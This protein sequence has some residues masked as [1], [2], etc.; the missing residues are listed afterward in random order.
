[1]VNH[2]RY[3]I[4]TLLLGMGTCLP[5]LAQDNCNRACMKS[6]VDS[7]LSAIVA[8]DPNKAPLATIYRHTE[9]DQVQPRGEGMW[10]TA[11]G[12]GA[13]QRQYFDEVTKNAVYYG[14]IKEGDILA[15]TAVRLHIE[16]KLI[17][18]A[19][20]FVGRDADA[21]VDGIAGNTL[22]D[23]EYLTHGNPPLVRTVPPAERSTRAELE[24]ITNS[25]WDYVVDRNP[26]IVVAHPGCYRE[27][28][29]Q[30]T[31]GT[32]LPPERINDG[33][34]DGMSD[35]RSGSS[36]FNVQN[37]TARRWH[38]IDVEQQAVV[39]SAL[40]IREPG[41]AKRRNHF[42]DVFYI[43]EGK[44]RGLYTAMYYVP[45]TRAVPNWPPYAGNFP[46]AESFGPTK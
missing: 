46:L 39:A 23:A 10:K 7:Y 42:C 12:L 31:V 4:G 36:T 18:E 14:T 9:N 20:W 44:L 33:G 22:W 3:T 17:T 30:K 1:M 45:P 37:I 41:H 34:L 6:V 16:N 35:C 27:E 40:F 29:G 32:P 15:I 11:T 26:N 43:D 24:Y 19:E 5:A 13:M 8:H 2:Y 21:G 38:V 28:N 25:Y